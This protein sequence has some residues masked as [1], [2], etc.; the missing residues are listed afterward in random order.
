[1]IKRM[2]LILPGMIIRLREKMSTFLEMSKE[3]CR[4]E[5]TGFASK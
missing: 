4:K 2:S 3:V 5:R 1:M